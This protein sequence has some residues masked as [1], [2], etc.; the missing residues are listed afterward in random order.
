MRGANRLVWGTLPTNEAANRLYDSTG[1]KRSEWIE[2]E[3][4]L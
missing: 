4:E 2:Y 1:A 3:L